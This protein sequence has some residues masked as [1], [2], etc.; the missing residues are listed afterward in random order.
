[1]DARR[2]S[3]FIISDL[4]M[5]DSAFETPVVLIIFNRPEHTSKVLEKIREV[6]PKKLYVIADGPRADK[7]LDSE[8][9]LASRRQIEEIDWD[10]QVVM[11]YSDKNLG[12][13]DRVVSGLS[14]VFNEED[15]AIILEDDCLPSKSFFFFTK[16]LLDRYAEDTRVGSIGGTL[17]TGIS[18][19]S[20]ES[21]FFSHYPQ[22][23]GWGTWARVWRNYDASVTEWPTLR[24]TN[25]LEGRLSTKKAIANWKWNLDSVFRN[26]ID[27][28]DYQFVF[29]MWRHNLLTVIPSTNLISNIGFGPDATHTL[30]ASSKFSNIASADME[31]PLV[32]PKMV[33]TTSRDAA[34]ERLLFNT[35]LFETRIGALLSRS[36]KWLR[37]ILVRARSWAREHLTL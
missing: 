33:S 11:D 29:N 17:P 19:P 20:N 13:R 23:W 32:H 5:A 31:F 28:W 7:P 9:V 27:T 26:E 4:P 25:F 21:Y 16:N 34:I 2:E 10:C 18:A 8:L 24:K 22:I 30:D 35:S 12:C 1:M 6:R 36:P 37:A 14:S 15:R 3:E